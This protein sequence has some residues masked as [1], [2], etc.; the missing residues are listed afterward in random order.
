[1][2]KIV[3]RFYVQGSGRAPV[4][5]WLMDLSVEDRRTIGK[6]I[7]KV[8]FG[9]PLGMPLCRP[10]GDGLWE[11][12]SDLETGRISRI[13][14]GFIDNEMILLNGFIKKSRKCPKQEIELAVKRRKDLS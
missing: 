4:R 12:R 1:M 11:I 9:W 2:K 5:D 6:D 14:F 10:L 8:E 7:Q 3:A 13:I